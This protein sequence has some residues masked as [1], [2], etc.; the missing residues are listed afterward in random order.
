MTLTLDQGFSAS[1]LAPFA[2]LT[3]TGQIDGNFIAAQIDS[4]GEVH[5]VEFDGTLPDGPGTPS[6]VPEPG[7]LALLGTGVLSL[8]GILRKRMK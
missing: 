6:S 3:N 8:A 7:T 2:I 4:S 5:N 1:V